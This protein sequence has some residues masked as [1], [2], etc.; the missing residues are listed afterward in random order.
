MPNHTSNKLFVTGPDESVRRFVDHVNRAD[1]DGNN[2]FDLNA[3][4][5]MPPQLDLGGV[6]FLDPDKDT[7]DRLQRT[8][9]QPSSAITDA[10]RA[11]AKTKLTMLDNKEQFGFASWYEWSICKWGTKWNTYQHGAWETCEGGQ[12]LTYETAWN[13]PVPALLEGSKQF[14]DLTLTNKAADEGGCFLVVDTFRNG[15][16]WKD[17]YDW[18][19]PAGISLRQEL[20]C[21]SEPCSNC[22]VE[23][24]EGECVEEKEAQ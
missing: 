3:L 11:L 24:C 21:W 15:Q 23:G 12:C 5:P 20:D 13:P 10:E 1:G 18:N 4:V 2:P 6:P 8:I 7:R 14:P 17:S 22:N 19:S 16:Q 9:D